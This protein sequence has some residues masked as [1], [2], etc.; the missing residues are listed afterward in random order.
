MIC[1]TSYD[2]FLNYIYKSKLFTKLSLI[3]QAEFYIFANN[4][5]LT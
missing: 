2:N 1:A 5:A 4:A 3:E